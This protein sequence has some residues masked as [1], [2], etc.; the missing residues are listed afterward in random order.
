VRPLEGLG[1]EPTAVSDHTSE[2]FEAI[3][4]ATRKVYP[5]AVV[6]PA[7]FIAAADARHFA[8]ISKNTFRYM[9]QRITPQDR[10]RFHG[11]N[12]RI[13]VK[14]YANLVRFYRQVILESASAR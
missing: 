13:G 4:V 2:A 6:A 1:G 5:E 3:E 12:E 10:A 8:S 11:V 14:D 9:P 7:L